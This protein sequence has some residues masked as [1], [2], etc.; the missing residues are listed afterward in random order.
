MPRA[1]ADAGRRAVDSHSTSGAAYQAIG[2][3]ARRRREEILV[4]VSS[5]L[6]PEEAAHQYT[7]DH[8]LE[9]GVTAGEV[10]AA[11]ASG[12]ARSLG[13]RSPTA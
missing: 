2:R 4:L 10:E 6:T 7:R 9:R 8:P 12:K 5:G 11:V 1:G 3:R 13:P